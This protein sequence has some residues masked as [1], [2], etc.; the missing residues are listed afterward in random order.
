MSL[1]DKTGVRTP[2][3]GVLTYVS[4]SFDLLYYIG[5]L[6]QRMAILTKATCFQQLTANFSLCHLGVSAVSLSVFAE[7]A[8]T[9]KVKLQPLSWRSG[10]QGDAIQ[11]IVG[12]LDI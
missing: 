9:A 8:E 4:V 1:P 5:A 3:K 2:L 12:G 10:I 6:T 7:S 11:D